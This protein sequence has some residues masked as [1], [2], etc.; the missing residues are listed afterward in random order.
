MK[1]T[2]TRRIDGKWSETLV[3]NHKTGSFAAFNSKGEAVFGPAN[4]Q[5]RLYSAPNPTTGRR[6]AQGLLSSL[7]TA[8]LK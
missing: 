8:L 1:E 6:E 7:V 5:P 3:K 2:I 4:G